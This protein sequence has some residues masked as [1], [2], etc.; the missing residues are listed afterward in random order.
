V[1][2]SDNFYFCGEV[3]RLPERKTVG[4]ISISPNIRALRIYPVEETDRRVSELKTIGLKLSRGQA[5]HLARVLL[6][7]TQEWDEVDITAYRLKRRRSDGTYQ[8]T[9]TSIP[10]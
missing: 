6:A 1:G 4:S 7:V 2:A 9:V 3:V 10:D 5:I 8:V